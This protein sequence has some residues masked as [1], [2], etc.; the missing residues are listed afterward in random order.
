[1]AQKHE[2][3]ERL[4]LTKALLKHKLY[5]ELDMI[6]TRTIAVAEGEKVEKQNVKSSEEK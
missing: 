5:D 4:L 3:L 2:S 1:M 6:V